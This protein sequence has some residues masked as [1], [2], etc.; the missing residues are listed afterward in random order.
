M[1]NYFVLF[2][3]LIF[4]SE[5]AGV[6]ED[7]LEIF[8]LL[9]VLVF[10]IFGSV[11]HSDA[12]RI[13]RFDKLFRNNEFVNGERVGFVG[14]CGYNLVKQHLLIHHMS[15]YVQRL[16]LLVVLEV[17]FRL[18]DHLLR[19]DY[20]IHDFETINGLLLVFGF[21]QHELLLV[22]QFERVLADVFVLEPVGLL[23]VLLVDYQETVVVLE[24]DSLESQAAVLELDYQH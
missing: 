23:L 22:E 21:L 24:T 19:S 1:I 6:D 2:R 7:G 10:G 14:N 20:Q 11:F 15:H 12:T 3:D 4:V 5:V 9:E 8:Y 16:V 13:P 17:Y 18:A